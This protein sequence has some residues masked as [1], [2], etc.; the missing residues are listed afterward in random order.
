MLLQALSTGTWLVPWLAC[1]PS[2]DRPC[3]KWQLHSGTALCNLLFGS[4]HVGLD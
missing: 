2:W 4:L 1:C 3:I